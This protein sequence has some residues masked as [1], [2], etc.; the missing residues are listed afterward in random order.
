[1][2]RDLQEGYFIAVQLADGDTRPIW[3]ARALS[4]PNCNPEKT[5]CML[6]QYF[7]STLRNRDVQDNYIRWNSKRGLRW[8]VHE[9]KPPLRK[10][11]NALMIAWWSPI[12]KETIECM[13]KIPAAQ[14]E[15]INLNLA[16][17]TDI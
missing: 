3:I 14:I 10:E 17:Y 6:I 13:I 4:D 7:R 1:V 11:T 9:A 5:N 16:L 8:K 2:A 15:I 12:K